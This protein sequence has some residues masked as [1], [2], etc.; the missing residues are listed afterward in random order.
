[1]LEVLY[2]RAFAQEFRIRYDCAI[3]IG[4][5]LADNAFDLVAGADRHGRFGDHDGEAVERSR[6]LACGLMNE[7]QVGETIAAARGRTNRD[8]HRISCGNRASEFRREFQPARARIVGDQVIKAGLIDRH[9]AAAQRRDLCLVLVD[10]DNLVPEVGKA[11]AGNKADIAG[12]DHGNAHVI[13][14]MVVTNRFRSKPDR[15]CIAD[16]NPSGERRRLMCIFCDR[17]FWPID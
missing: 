9:L 10:A 15:D 16:E 7:A 4:P 11:S 5:R 3:G 17:I 2:G 12:A 14:I 13:S 6:D 8:E 1:M